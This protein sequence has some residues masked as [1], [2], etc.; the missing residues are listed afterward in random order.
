MGGAC[1]GTEA[2]TGPPIIMEK[3]GKFKVNLSP[4]SG[5]ARY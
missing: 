1:L 5:G 2:C 4:P 3:E